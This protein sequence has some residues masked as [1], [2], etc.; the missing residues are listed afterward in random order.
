MLMIYKL[1]G[2]REN[3]AEILVCDGVVYG[4]ENRTTSSI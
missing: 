3:A 2:E 1:Y 4:E